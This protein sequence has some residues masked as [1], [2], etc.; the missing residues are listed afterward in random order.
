MDELQIGET[1][2]IRRSDGRMHP[3]ICTA[4]NFDLE[5]VTTEWVEDSIIK[6]KNMSFAEILAFNPQLLDAENIV[7]NVIPEVQASIVAPPSA[8]GSMIPPFPRDSSPGDG[9]PDS[10]RRSLTGDPYSERLRVVD[11]RASRLPRTAR[12]PSQIPPPTATSRMTS[13][14][15]ARGSRSRPAQSSTSVAAPPVPAQSSTSVAAPPVRTPTPAPASSPPSNSGQRCSNVVRQVERLREQRELRRARQ[16]EQIL[17]KNALRNKDPGNPN[18]EQALMVRQYRET[19]TLSPLRFVDPNRSDL[20]QISVCVRKRPMNRRELSM[21]SVDII[22]VPTYDSVIVHELRNKV[23][24]TK[25]LEHHRFRFDYTFDEHCSNTLVYEHTARPLI[26]TMFEGGNAT[27]FAYGQTGSGKTHTMGG[28][29]CGKVQDCR[30]GIYA[31]AARDVFEQVSRPEYKKAGANITCS[32]FE[33]YGSKILDLLHPDKPTLRILEDGRQHVVIV[34][35]TEM[36][37]TKVEDVLL[38]IDVGNKARTSGQTSANAK[39]SR[40]HAVFQISLHMPDTWGACGKC[41]FVDLAGNERGADTQTDSR[42]ARLEGA[43]INRSLLALKECI[44][45]LSQHSGHLPFR[46][47]KLTQVL[48]DSF[49]GG[50]KNKTCMIAMVSPSMKCLENT[51]NTLRYAD[52]VKELIARDGESEPADNQDDDPDQGDHSEHEGYEDVQDDEH[53]NNDLPDPSPNDNKTNAYYPDGEMCDLELSNLDNTLLQNGIKYRSVGDKVKLREVAEQH[54]ALLQ[55]LESFVSKFRD[56]NLDQTE[57]SEYLRT[58]DAHFEEMSNLVSHT[59]D[60]VVNYNAQ[61]LINGVVSKNIGKNLNYDD[62]QPE[63]EDE[64]MY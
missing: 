49:I 58:A 2:N 39:S 32:F 41:S 62:D 61:Q 31:M 26:R 3:A 37:V 1:V 5:T 6:N 23:D 44:R 16:A 13:G 24:L 33:I 46:G 11:V 48:R 27:C 22:T 4:K 57:F 45:A 19:I 55:Y 12:R 50:S 25:I 15:T 47:S 21:K 20:Q 14:G 29:F 54:E 30:G 56:L 10:Y 52:R 40:S 42:Q 51:L 64:R 17:E 38:L 18:W 8:A 63:K 9:P 59:R 28:E 7:P 34:G 36:P 53:Y 60:M 35:L 43:E